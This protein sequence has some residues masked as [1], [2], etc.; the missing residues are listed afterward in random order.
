MQTPEWELQSARILFGYSMK[1]NPEDVYDILQQPKLEDTPRL[2]EMAIQGGMPLDL[3]HKTGIAV[4]RRLL[5][6]GIS[7]VG[8]AMQTALQHH[9]DVSFSEA[10][11]IAKDPRTIDF[12]AYAARHNQLSTESILKHGILSEDGEAIIKD[13]KFHPAAPGLPRQALYAG[14]PVARSERSQNEAQPVFK[15]FVPWAAE[16]CLRAIYHHKSN[17]TA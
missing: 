10:V 9:S 7:D 4:T 1:F 8:N 3:R 2:T 15:A 5:S 12:I 17:E 14:C 13:P 16:L 6:A 11:D